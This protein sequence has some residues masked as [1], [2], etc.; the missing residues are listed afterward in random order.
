MVNVIV[1]LTCIISESNYCMCLLCQTGSKADDGTIAT[2]LQ[3]PSAESDC[4]HGPAPDY[5]M[6]A[7]SY[8]SYASITSSE[9]RKLV[10]TFF[11]FPRSNATHCM[12]KEKKLHW[13]SMMAVRALPSVGRSSDGQKNSK[14]IERAHIFIHYKHSLLQLWIIQHTQIQSNRSTLRL[15]TTSSC[16]TS[17]Q[18]MTLLDLLRVLRD[19]AGQN[20]HLAL[21]LVHELGLVRTARRDRIGGC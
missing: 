3:T 18:A 5:E 7:I 19:L 15:S 21:D 9:T 10:A 6:H 8:A 12:G 2:P 16:V 20:L 4:G 14:W 1:R 13:P 11:V 17:L